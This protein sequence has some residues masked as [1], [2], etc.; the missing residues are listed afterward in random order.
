[1]QSSNLRI[2][3]RNHARKAILAIALAMVLVPWTVLAAPPASVSETAF[4]NPSPRT[5]SNWAQ[6]S[7][8][9]GDRMAVTAWL[10]VKA[11]TAVL[12]YERDANGAWALAYS[13]D[14][15]ATEPHTWHHFGRNLAL[16]GDDLLVGS[17][18]SNSIYF[19]RR[20]ADGAWNLVKQHT[21]TNFVNANHAHGY[22]AHGLVMK[23]GIA[24]VTLPLNHNLPAMGGMRV[25][26]RTEAGWDVAYTF[27][28]ICCGGDSTKST[29]MSV[30]LND[31]G[32][33]FLGGGGHLQGVLGFLRTGERTWS[34]P[35]N[36]GSHGTGNAPS[37]SVNDGLLAIGYQTASGPRVRVWP[38]CIVGACA[39]EFSADFAV[40]NG[41]VYKGVGIIRGAVAVGTNT[42]MDLYAFNGTTYVL[43]ESWSGYWG[44]G[45]YDVVFEGDTLHVTTSQASA[46]AA[47]GIYSYTFDG[48]GDGL[49]VWMEIRLRTDPN[50]ADTD[51]DLVSDGAEVAGGSDPTNPGSVPTPAGAVTVAQ[52]DGMET[53]VVDTLP[54]L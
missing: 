54:P 11:A 40:P 15:P 32:D 7:A 2:S 8:I 21:D 22:G 43:A 26:A 35:F 48:D 39:S 9:D 38:A 46:T 24:V 52:T 51:G 53:P 4:T 25:F 29:L 14:L 6:D 47:P 5:I 31:E 1:M 49:P 44:F 13:I 27:R 18:Y 10:N 3:D 45:H 23:D 16:D 12:I 17:L 34:G 42:G 41:T 30:A 28:E 19:Y 36:F 37:V 50:D 33:I 20:A